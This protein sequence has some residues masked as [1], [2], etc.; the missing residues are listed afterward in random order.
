[1][2]ALSYVCSFAFLVSFIHI[3]DVKYKTRSDQ[4]IGSDNGVKV[5]MTLKM[6]RD[7]FYQFPFGICYL[8]DKRPF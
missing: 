5:C 6:K 1:M 7:Y 4:H 8:A 2:S 3:T